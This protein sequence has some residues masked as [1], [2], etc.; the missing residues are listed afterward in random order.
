MS[1]AG[2]WWALA[3]LGACASEPTTPVQTVD[4]P[5][6]A[7]IPSTSTATG[8][9]SSSPRA[10]GDHPPPPPICGRLSHEAMTVARWG[11]P[12]NLG[13]G[14]DCD[15][16][17][18]T[19]AN[20]AHVERTCLT[21]SDCVAVRGNGHCFETSLNRQSV[22]LPRYAKPPCGNPTAGACMNRHLSPRCAAGCCAM[23]P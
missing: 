2:W 4:L 5:L 23:S 15:A 16:L 17:A 9:P 13:G 19:W 18:T 6:G 11:F 1:Y 21:D 20:V 12:P 8:A 14:N 10:G 22:M 7:P 3:L